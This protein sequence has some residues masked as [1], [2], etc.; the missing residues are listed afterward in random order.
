MFKNYELWVNSLKWDWCVSRQR[1]YGVPFPFWYCQKCGEVILPKEEDLPVNPLEDKPPLSRCPICQSEEIVPETDVMD[2]WATSSCT[3]FLLRELGGIKE[4]FPVDL[5]PNAHEII[6]TWDFYS[7]VKS[8]Y[9]FQEIPFKNI[10]ISGHG[11]DEKGKKISKR[12]GNYV[13]S[14]ELVEKYGA[15]AVRYWAT[16][17]SLGQNLRFN[18]KEIKKGRQLTIKLWNVVRFILM[19]RAEIKEEPKLETPDLWIIKRT[20]ETIKKATQY[21]DDYEYAKARNEIETFFMSQ[22]ADYYIEFV[23]YRLNSTDEESK[24]AAQ[25]VLD[26]VFTNIIKMF[27]PFLPFVTEE[28]YQLLRKEKSVHLSTWPEPMEAK[29]PDSDFEQ[30]IKAIDEIRKYKSENKISLGKEVEEYHLQTK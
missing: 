28:I 30:A 20:N 15:D 13:S 3:P 2:T 19:D 22:F 16:G 11:L 1:Y 17:A 25:Y 5:R 23:K 18:E 27:A 8:Y 12:L 7:I 9:H 6:R 21:F 14:E 10:M 29:E 26:S 4:L 24:Q